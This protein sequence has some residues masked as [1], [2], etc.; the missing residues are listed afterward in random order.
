[1]AITKRGEL[2]GEPQITVHGLLNGP[3][4]MSR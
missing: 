1:M 4:R 3:T 2:L